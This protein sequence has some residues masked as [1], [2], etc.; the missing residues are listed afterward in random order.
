MQI[1]TPKTILSKWFLRIGN[2]FLNFVE[3]KI[4]LSIKI[5]KI[6]HLKQGKKPPRGEAW[7][8]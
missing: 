6:V 3:K 4:V 5:L 1:Y 2:R 7:R 8:L